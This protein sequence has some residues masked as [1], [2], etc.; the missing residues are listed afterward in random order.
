MHVER[1]IRS[2]AGYRVSSQHF[3]PAT[4]KDDANPRDN[5]SGTP[6]GVQYAVAEHLEEAH[7]EVEGADPTH[8]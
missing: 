5:R 3:A 2:A 8:R 7:L 4:A 1:V 6:D